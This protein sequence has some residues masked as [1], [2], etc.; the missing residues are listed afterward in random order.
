MTSTA[1]AA[2]STINCV[3]G[4]C[5]ALYYLS[6]SHTTPLYQIFRAPSDVQVFALFVSSRADRVAGDRTTA[7]MTA[8]KACVIPRAACRCARRAPVRRPNP[9]AVACPRPFC[10]HRTA[11]VCVPAGS[12]QLPSPPYFLR[13]RR[14]T[15]S[16][17]HSSVECSVVRVSQR[18]PTRRI[19]CVGDTGLHI[20]CVLAA[21]YFE[22]QALRQSQ[23]ADGPDPDRRERAGSIRRGA[24]SSDSLSTSRDITNCNCE[25][26]MWKGSLRVGR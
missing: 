13:M 20:Y 18:C 1:D 15:R 6:L 5:P 3:I 24:A 12:L 16:A 26:G 4:C 21:L 25:R 10:M 7:L 11:Q 14:S 19:V 9:D 17:T 22:L 2:R 23:R 8:A